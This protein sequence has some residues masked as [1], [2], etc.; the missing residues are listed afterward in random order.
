MKHFLLS[1]AVVLFSTSAQAED[2]FGPIRD[3]L[4]MCAACHGA[5]GQGGLG[6]KLNGQSADD[7][8]A[9]LL[10]YKA[11]ETVGPQSPLM[12]ANAQNLTEGQIG[13]L[14]VYYSQG[15]PSE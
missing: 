5:Q 6:P 11:G 12:W 10:K 9:K 3:Q 1:L 15:M 8:V 13:M 14:A 7:L 2:R 4:M